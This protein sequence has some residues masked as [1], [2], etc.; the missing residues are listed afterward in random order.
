MY[1]TR[2]SQADGV[3]CRWRFERLAYPVDGYT[4]NV[5]TQGD[6]GEDDYAEEGYGY[7]S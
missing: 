1:L 4:G 7:A 6:Y 2:L 3:L 5:A